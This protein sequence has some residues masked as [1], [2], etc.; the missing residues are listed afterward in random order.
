MSFLQHYLISVIRL[1]KQASLFSMPI[2]LVACVA[3]PVQKTDE[4]LVEPQVVEEVKAELVA[5]PEVEPLPLTPELIYYLT[6]AEIAGQ[7]GQMGTAVDL[8]YKASTVSESSSL[9]SRSAEIALFSRDQKRIDRALKRWT[10]VDPDDAEIYITRAPFLMLQNDFDGVVEAVNIA[11]KLSP[12]RSREF[13]SRVSD[14]LIELASADQAMHVIEQLELYKKNDP[15]ALFAYSRL[16]SFSKRYDDALP[17]V[18]QVLEQ[19]VNR[20]DALVLKAEILQSIGEGDKAIAVLK[21]AAIQDGASVSVRFS[22][23]KLLGQNKKIDESRAAFQQ[24]HAEQPENEE[25]IFALGL[26]AME[27]QDGEVAKGY[28]NKLIVLGDRGQQASYFMGL[29]EELNKDNDAALIWYA[30]VPA[31]SQRF[32]AAQTRYINLLADNGDLNKARLHLKLLRKEQPKRAI[33]YYLFE[34]QFLI[35]RGQKQA[36]FDLYTEALKENVGNFDLLHG[37]AMVAEPLNRLDVLEKDLNEI[38][39]KDPNNHQALNALGYTLADRTDRYQ[40]AFE[41]INKAV[42][43]KPDDAFYL[44]SL[45]W[46]YYRLG[47]LEKAVDYLRQAVVIRPDVELLTH[48][49]EVL[50]VQG[51]HDEAKQIWQKATKKEATNKLLNDTMRR[52]EQ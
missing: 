26:L 24:L 10:E 11:L 52:L 2:L 48:L 12:D 40:E 3:T 50:W 17:A 49:G 8:Y 51:K 15:E 19:Q 5:E 13:L 1:F 9:A 23:A 29:A 35:E 32:N 6:V 38:L 37:R 27:E 25:V 7:R 39:E 18:E 28:F 45:G 41:L 46:V 36:A 14:N 31:D 4:P 34:A 21:Q 43:L 22:Y 33:Q 16:A 30:S 42:A 47:E 44:D 20:E